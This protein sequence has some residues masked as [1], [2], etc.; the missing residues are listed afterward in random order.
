MAEYFSGSVKDFLMESDEVI[1]AKLHTSYAN[2]GFSSQYTSATKA[3]GAT[4]TVLRPHLKNLIRDIP[5]AEEWG[6]VLEYPLYRLRIRL[7][8]VLLSFQSIYVIELKT[9]STEYLSAD[10]RQV[11]EYA[12][13]LRY[14][15]SGSSF[16]EIY[17]ILW[18]PER[19]D[20]LDKTDFKVTD[21]VSS[22]VSV[23]KNNLIPA[24]KKLEL[25]T[26]LNKKKLSLSSWL[27]SEY[28]PVPSII[29]AATAIFGNHGVK[30]I[31]NSDA[32]NLAIAGEEITKLI[33]KAKNL[34][35]HYLIFLSGVPGS[36]KTLAGLKVVHDVLHD[37]MLSAGEIVYLSGNTPLVVVLREALALDQVSQAQKNGQKKS[38]T[39]KRARMNM[40]VTIQHVMDFLNQ[41]LKKEIFK[42]PID[43]VVVFDEA[44]RAWDE[45]QGKVKFDRQASEPEL[46]LSIMERHSD[47]AVVVALIGVGQEINDGEYG[48]SG[49]GSALMSRFNSGYRNWKIFGSDVSITGLNIPSEKVP[50]E[51]ISLNQNLHLIVSQRSYRAPQLSEWVNLVISGNT[52]GAKKIKLSLPN[53]P[54]MITRD[55]EAMKKWLISQARG[56]RR[57]GLLASSGARRLRPDG[58]GEF[59][60]ANDGV[61]IAHWYLKPQGDLRS[62]FALEVPA[63]EYTSQGLEI[64]Y[65]GLCWGGDLI[66]LKTG[67]GK[68]TVRKLG[69]TRWTTVKVDSGQRFVENSYRVL[70]TRA[71]EGMVIWIP[72]GDETDETRS[73]E[74]FD[75]IYS[76]LIDCGAEII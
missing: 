40:R 16:T 64:D 5:E 60:H 43:H 57:I 4:L 13:D 9:G 34:G 36:G 75:L 55:K 39:L 37:Q 35:E 76:Y 52:D 3:W 73:P 14:F 48:L 50:S 6:L 61:S 23:G 72:N 66:R 44:Q 12:L 45:K 68:W 59:L 71:R 2:D 10:K 7:D 24:I 62:S 22:V 27:S 53:Y 33:K 69:G 67:D 51:I 18:C 26:P 28:K 31:S 1:Q 15:H 74:E 25:N 8:L 56:R 29:S 63:N 11:E 65:V 46:V 19:D 58:Y 54:V 47:W 49:W 21:F 17:P 32:D 30:E 38:L 41:Y 20:A 70:M 42:P